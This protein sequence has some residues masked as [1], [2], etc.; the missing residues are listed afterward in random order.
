MSD[1]LCLSADFKLVCDKALH[2][3]IANRL[4]P[5]NILFELQVS[6]NNIMNIAGWSVEHNFIV[7]KCI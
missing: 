5:Q 6:M 3:E 4:I 1:I 2:M 7:S